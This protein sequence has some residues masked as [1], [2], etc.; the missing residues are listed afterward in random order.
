MIEVP[1]EDEIKEIIDEE[2]APPEFLCPD[3]LE[4]MRDP[5]MASDGITY[6]R[7]LLENWINRN[8]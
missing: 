3:T 6:E 8:K 2:T 4:I 5:V 1:R 7:V